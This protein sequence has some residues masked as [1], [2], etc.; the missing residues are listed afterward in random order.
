MGYAIHFHVWRADTFLEFFYAA[1]AEAGLD[2]EL[3][4]FAP[5]EHSTDD[6][7]VVV[8][9]KGRPAAVRMPTAPLAHPSPLSA[10]GQVSS[11]LPAKAFR[12][13]VREG[14]RPLVLKTAAYLRRLVDGDGMGGAAHPGV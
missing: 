10:R 11:S 2:L 9:L 13:L 3:A 4:A 6:E 14:P 7:F 12:T 8:L 1:R 5:P